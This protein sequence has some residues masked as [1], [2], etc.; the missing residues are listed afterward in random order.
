MKRFSFL[1]L[2]LVLSIFSESIA[3]EH[4]VF[5]GKE[6]SE[7]ELFKVLGG[8]KGK[9]LIKFP[10]IKTKAKFNEQVIQYI[11][12]LDTVYMYCD[13]R[14]NNMSVISNDD[15]TIG[16]LKGSFDFLESIANGENEISI[17]AADLFF[18]NPVKYLPINFKDKKLEEKYG[19]WREKA[20]GELS[21]LEDKY[22]RQHIEEGY[23]SL[24]IEANIISGDVL[25]K[26]PIAY[27]KIV[28]DEDENFQI[29]E[30]SYGFLAET[31]I[32]PNSTIKSEVVS[33]NE[34]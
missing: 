5:K 15:T 18:V 34:G 27:L 11:A 14:I 32:S 16:A 25:E 20:S 3:T 31:E 9:E 17:E 21:L 22:R 10:E 26:R 24:L 33:R 2:F 30:E 19:E 29:S 23:C 13:V 1:W 4:K 7:M 6:Y 8:D 12:T 28:R